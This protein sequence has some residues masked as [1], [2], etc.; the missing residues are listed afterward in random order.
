MISDLISAL[1]S[2]F[3]AI[4]Y[5]RK[6]YVWKYLFL[7][8]VLSVLVFLALSWFIFGFGDN[9]SSGIISIFT[10]E[11][12]PNWIDKTIQYLT[13]I[14]LWILL[15]LIFK[16]V[17]LA[18]TAPILSLLSERVEKD[19]NSAFA[20]KP[21]KLLEQIQL[22]GRGSRIAISNLLRELLMTIPLMV[23]SLIPAITLFVTAL[24]F[25]I[26]AYYA[27]FGTMDFTLERYFNVKESRRFVSQNRFIAIGNGAIF[28][29]LFL[30]PI[31]GAFVAPTLSTIASTI[32]VL[33]K[34]E[35][36]D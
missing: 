34:L 18:I 17:I 13:S 35:E 22:V 21:F 1:K 14:T 7:S 15:L 20:T 6:P 33:D 16:Y 32:N 10:S 26:Q 4:A 25:M 36:Y 3:E 31:L 12:V 29:L 30:I 19:I 8:G 27:G 9:M 11:S 23:M 28:L 24:I 5:L 2:Y